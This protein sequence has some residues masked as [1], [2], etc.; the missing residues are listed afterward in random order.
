MNRVGQMWVH[1]HDLYLCVGSHE[2]APGVWMHIFVDLGANDTH[3][4][5]ES[6]R[7]R[8]ND[9]DLSL[10]WKRLDG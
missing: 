3:T 5:E 1:N 6:E 9:S 8:W 4:F 10:Y 7:I 2:E